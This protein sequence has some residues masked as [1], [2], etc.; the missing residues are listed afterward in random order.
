MVDAIAGVHGSAI[1]DP[2]LIATTQLTCE[3]DELSLP[4]H[5]KSQKEPTTW[6]DELRRQGVHQLIANAMHRNAT[7]SRTVT[8]RAKRAGAALLS[9]TEMPMEQIEAHLTQYWG[10][11]DG[12]A[13]PLRSVRARTVDL[14]PVV[15]RII[16]I[17]NPGLKCGDRVDRLL[18]RLEL[19]V[20]APLVVLGTLLGTRLSRADYLALRKA[21]MD[22]VERLRIAKDEDL[23][24]LLGNSK[25]KLRSVQQALREAEATEPS[26]LP[27]DPILPPY[28]A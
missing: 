26:N 10:K 27:P 23:L 1:N 11:F 21:G 25:E 22:S 2:T 8:L 17:K 18:I 13:G 14:L 16:E 12:A 9:I 28:Q 3:L 7:D 19:G 20:P 6:F 4:M 5:A 15:A 24:R